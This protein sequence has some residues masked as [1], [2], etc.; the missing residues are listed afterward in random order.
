MGSRGK[1]VAHLDP[2]LVMVIVLLSHS[3][4]LCGDMAWAAKPVLELFA[5]SA[6]GLPW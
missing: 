6:Q 4:E 1:E 3:K 2:C 5:I